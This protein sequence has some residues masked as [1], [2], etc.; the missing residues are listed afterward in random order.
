MPIPSVSFVSAPKAVNN[1][2]DENIVF[3][4]HLVGDERLVLSIMQKFSDR[5]VVLEVGCDTSASFN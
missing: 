2:G 5:N 3:L 1:F 4:R